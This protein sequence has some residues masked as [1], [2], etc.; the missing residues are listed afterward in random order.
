M[1]SY[2]LICDNDHRFDAWFK[3]ADAFDEQRAPGI[4]SCPACASTVVRKAPMAPAVSR[5]DTERV[6]LTAGSPGHARLRE[7]IIALRRKVISE[8]DYVGDRFAEEAR[9]IHFE[10]ADPR[11]IYGEAT[12]DEVAGL[13]EDGV[14]FLPLP[15]MPEDAN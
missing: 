4:V 7:A 12:R 5:T 3:N 14:D 15:R 2:T 10:E 11:A 13:I 8:A 1:I 6:P 9:R